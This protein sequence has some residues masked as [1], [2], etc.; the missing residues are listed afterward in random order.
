M[1]GVEMGQINGFVM[2]QGHESF[3]FWLVSR[4][5]LQTGA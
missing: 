4:M 1:S 5:L 2:D 3:S